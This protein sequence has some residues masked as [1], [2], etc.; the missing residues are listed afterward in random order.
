MK[1]DGRV[2]AADCGMEL[3][4]SAQLAK[5]SLERKKWAPYF[6]GLR[7]SAADPG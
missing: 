2:I 6:C 7:C 5:P 3:F 1:T 4:Y